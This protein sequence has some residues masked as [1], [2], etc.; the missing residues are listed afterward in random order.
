MT[1]NHP[2]CEPTKDQI[3]YAREIAEEERKAWTER[4]P[5]KR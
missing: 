4:G 2:E 3:E 1:C 5:H